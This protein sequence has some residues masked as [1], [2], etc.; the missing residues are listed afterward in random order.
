M[1]HFRCTHNQ[2]QP[3]HICLFCSVETATSNDLYRHITDQH[4]KETDELRPSLLAARSDAQEAANKQSEEQ[5]GNET[6]NIKAEQ[7][8]MEI[9]SS[10]EPKEVRYEPITEDFM[11][12]DRVISPCY[13]VLPYVN[14]EEVEAACN[15]L[16][17]S[18]EFILKNEANFFSKTCFLTKLITYS[19]L[20]S[21]RGATC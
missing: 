15:A 21:G 6:E 8:P 14:D 5:N 2:K 4:Q 20:G 1:K 12:E 3:P 10:E 16:P 11:Y 19:I 13:V 9:E 17:V 18:S 7:Q